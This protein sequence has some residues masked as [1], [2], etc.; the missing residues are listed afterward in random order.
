MSLPIDTL[1]AIME[2]QLGRLDDAERLELLDRLV[3]EWQAQR[4]ELEAARVELEG[5]AAS[6]VL[7]DGGSPACGL[8]L[9]L[10]D[11]TRAVRVQMVRERDQ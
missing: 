1:S 10:N 6:V 3:D 9:L 8:G 5:W 2:H 7:V 4:L 11:F